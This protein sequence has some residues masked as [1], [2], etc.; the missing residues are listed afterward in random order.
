MDL[1]RTWGVWWGWCV[2]VLYGIQW[3]CQSKSAINLRFISIRWNLSPVFP[4]PLYAHSSSPHIVRQSYINRAMGVCMYMCVCVKSPGIE[5]A[6]S[7]THQ[8]ILYPCRNFNKVTLNVFYKWVYFLLLLSTH[9]W[10]LSH[11]NTGDAKR[12]GPI[13]DL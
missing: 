8:R 2:L 13:N 11:P 7:E 12:Y 4:L 10:R 5:S 1:H 6:W 9:I 3:P